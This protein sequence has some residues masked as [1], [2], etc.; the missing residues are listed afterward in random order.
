MGLSPMTND[1][2]DSLIMRRL[3]VFHSAMIRRWRYLPAADALPTSLIVT[4]GS[5][6][7]P[8]VGFFVEADRP[9]SGS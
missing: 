9:I 7:V 3:I 2:V 4:G 6:V 1:E 8:D 5:E